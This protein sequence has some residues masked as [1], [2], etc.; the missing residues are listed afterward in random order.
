MKIFLKNVIILI[1]FVSNANALPFSPATFNM[2]NPTSIN[3]IITNE[4]EE[5]CEGT[6]IEWRMQCEERKRNAK[7]DNETYTNFSKVEYKNIDDECINVY[8]SSDNP[9]INMNNSVIVNQV[10]PCFSNQNQICS[11]P[12]C[13]LSR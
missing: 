3:T 2:E 6:G 7:N 12:I 5:K 11:E 13:D 8:T 1:L 4:D 9:N 10:K